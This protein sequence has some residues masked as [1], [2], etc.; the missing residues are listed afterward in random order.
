MVIEFTTLDLIEILPL[1]VMIKL[2]LHLFLG[3]FF[4]FILLQSKIRVFKERQA[5]PLLLDEH[6]IIDIFSVKFKVGYLKFFGN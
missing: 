3:Q 1:L 2:Y 6:C 4:F 5:S